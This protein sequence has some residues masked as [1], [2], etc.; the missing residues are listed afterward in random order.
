MKK[1][2][3]LNQSESEFEFEHVD[4]TKSMENPPKKKSGPKAPKSK[5]QP[6][7]NK[8]DIQEK[9]DEEIEQSFP[10]SDPPSQSQPHQED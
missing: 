10:A 8:E 4:P 2:K 1:N 6:V 5:K 9:L 7:E 3:I